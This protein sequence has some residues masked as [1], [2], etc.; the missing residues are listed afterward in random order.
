MAIK[1]C[2]ARVTRGDEG[3]TPRLTSLSTGR[4]LSRIALCG[5]GWRR[6]PALL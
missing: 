2:V 1:A 6:R 5:S 4:A 3:I